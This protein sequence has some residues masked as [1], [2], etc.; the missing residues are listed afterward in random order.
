MCFGGG[1]PY[2]ISAVGQRLYMTYI[3]GCSGVYSFL[4]KSDNGTLVP[5]A[6]FDVRHHFEK[7]GWL[8]T[9]DDLAARGTIW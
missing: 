3:F 9:L 5:G 4:P 1:V 8:E 7:T 6:I 2:F